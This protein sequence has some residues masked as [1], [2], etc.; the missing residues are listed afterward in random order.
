VPEFVAFDARILA[1]DTVTFDQ[2]ESFFTPGTVQVSRAFKT[3]LDFAIKTLPVG[4]VVV[5]GA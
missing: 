5:F 1:L 3:V 4:Q 2:F